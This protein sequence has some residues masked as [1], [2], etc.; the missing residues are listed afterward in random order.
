MRSATP[1]ICAFSPHHSWM[2]TTAGAVALAGSARYP[3]TLC[4][5]GRR[6]LIIWPMALLLGELSSRSD[7]FRALTCSA[8]L[9]VPAV[10]HHEPLERRAT[11]RAVLAVGPPERDD[12]GALDVV[13]NAE[14]LVD[15]RLAAAVQRRQHGSEAERAR[16][17]HEVLYAR[18]DRGAGLEPRLSRGGRVDAGDDQHRRRGERLARSGGGRGPARVGGSPRLLVGLAHGLLHRGVADHDEVPGL[19][20]R[21][22]GAVDRRRENPVDEL[23]RD[24]LVGEAAD[25]ALPAKELLHVGD[26]PHRAPPCLSEILA[27]TKTAAWLAP[28]EPSRAA[29]SRIPPL[30]LRCS[31]WWGRGDRSK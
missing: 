25:R 16:G 30:R 14:D 11:V 20:V 17:Q 26:G 27:A 31:P 22:G 7:A 24:V 9:P 28:A 2:T 1:L 23:V 15:A 13:R 12:R 18:I 10:A 6:K 21:A 19:G 4:P 5:S 8:P 3:C 29:H